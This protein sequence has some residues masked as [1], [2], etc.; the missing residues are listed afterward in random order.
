MIIAHDMLLRELQRIDF[1]GRGEEFVESNFLTPLLQCLGYDEH[2]DYE[3]IRHGD[4]RSSF[5]LKY[6][7]VEKGARKIKHYDPDYI[8]TIRKKMFWIVEAK[9]PKRARYPFATKYLVQGLQYCIHP[10]IQAQYLLVSN[11]VVSS[12]F[13]A[14][15][16]VFLG[17][18]MYAPILEFRASELAKRW[19]EIYELLGV[20]KL[21]TRIEEGLTIAYDK[22]CL[23]SL[24]K[25][26]PRKLLSRIGANSRENAKRVAASVNR[27]FVEQMDE[28]REAWRQTMEKMDVTQV[29]LSMDDPM[30]GG[31][32]TQAHFFVNKTISRGDSLSHILN[33]L[34][35]NFERQN[36]FR[37]EQT[38]LAVCL[39]YL[40]SDDAATQ[41]D[42]KAFL[43]KYKDADLP[44]LNQAEC[45]LLRL[46]RKTSVLYT[47]P[48]LRQQ[49][50]ERL[51]SAPEL[52]RFVS[53]PSA[54]SMSYQREIE[55]H[56][57]TFKKLE[58]FSGEGLENLLPVILRV[59]A[60]LD[61]Q[62][63][64]ARKNLA[65]SEH[66]VLGL[67][68]YGEGGRHYSFRGMLHNLGI[69][70]R[71]DLPDATKF[72]PAVPKGSQ[73]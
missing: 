12:V 61:E 4:D 63:K 49:I 58:R 3:V 33:R 73:K 69:E 32:H 27:M 36:I 72:V 6:P 62:F 35:Y 41:Q 7:P 67:E 9:S 22:L 15:G 60:S 51:Q 56:H 44:L 53:P 11:G 39:L 18:D 59:E 57:V 23:S 43:D 8:P 16:A 24:D 17:R 13:D 31:P 30:P 28:D 10:E 48:T 34:T 68:I 71:P 66:Q 46:T 25:D 1:S 47:Y 20:E 45:A 37:K 65:D 21:R 55:F 29:F 50:A 52:I 2:K 19:R 38:F 40:Q 5:R 54:L 14:H 26:Y 42:A 70:K 64:E